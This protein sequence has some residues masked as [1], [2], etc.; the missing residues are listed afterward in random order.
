MIPRPIC[1]LWI[2]HSSHS[3][4]SC[5]AMFFQGDDRPSWILSRPLLQ[6]HDQS[7]GMRSTQSCSTFLT[8]RRRP[9]Q[10]TVLPPPRPGRWTTFT[11]SNV[12]THSLLLFFPAFCFVV[13]YN[14]QLFLLFPFSFLFVALQII[15]LLIYLDIPHVFFTAPILVYVFSTPIPSYS[16]FLYTRYWAF[17]SPML[18][19]LPAIYFISIQIIPPWRRCLLS[20]TIVSVGCKCR[21]KKKKV[22]SSS[23]L[24]SLTANAAY[25]LSLLSRLLREYA[26]D[27]SPRTWGEWDLWSRFQAPE[28]D[29]QRNRARWFKNTDTLSFPC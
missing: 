5:R 26:F 22:G 2:R 17:P 23:A 24:F 20:H 28:K 13:S 27:F 10:L 12:Y 4:N 14:F 9:M 6:T 18:Y 15:A 21:L 25:F 19:P 7:I 11:L 16:F 8:R 29:T 1:Q 3:D